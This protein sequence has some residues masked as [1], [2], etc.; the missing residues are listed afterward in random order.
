MNTFR[1]K[2][3]IL[4][5]IAAVAAGIAGMLLVNW[6]WET[7]VAAGPLT[8]IDSACTWLGPL[9]CKITPIIL[10]TALLASTGSLGLLSRRGIGFA[11]GLVCGVALLALFVL[12]GLYGIAQL[13]VSGSAAPSATIIIKT[14]VYFLLVGIGEEFLARAVS[15]QT[16]LAHFGL[17]HA[18]VMKACALSGVIFGAM[19]F[20]NLLQLDVGSVLAQ[21]AVTTGAGILF[22]AIY[23]RCG[24]IWA[25]VILHMLWDATLFAAIS[26]SQITDGSSTA[27]SGNLGSLGFCAVLVA[28]SVFIL[29]KKKIAQVRKAWGDL[30]ELKSGD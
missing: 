4:Y 24:N 8:G 9:L 30:I 6:L 19:H 21:V 22:S 20:V 5:S 15:A 29:R 2:Y 16:L 13:V 10:S 18:G 17:T 27:G 25:C 1:T 28:I 7:G 12:F 11:R 3:P 23:F 26:G 14:A